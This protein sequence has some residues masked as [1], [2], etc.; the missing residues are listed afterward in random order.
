M[1]RF[2][3]CFILIAVILS[4]ISIPSCKDDT[5]DDYF[6]EFVLKNNASASLYQISSYN[7]L[8]S[9]ELFMNTLTE[10]IDSGVVSETFKSKTNLIKFAFKLS[11]NADANLWVTWYPTML[12]KGTKNEIL[13]NDTLSVTFLQSDT[14]QLIRY[15]LGAIIEAGWTEK[16]LAKKHNKLSIKEQIKRIENVISD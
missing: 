9:N 5:A 4:L 3:V 16:K 8:E 14:A 10:K 1:K 7:I 12:S 2:V 11:D 15:N 13:F 6:A